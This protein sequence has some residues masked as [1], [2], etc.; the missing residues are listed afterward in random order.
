MP[1]GS[2]S[3]APVINPGPNCPKNLVSGLSGGFPSDVF[4]NVFSDGFIA[5]FHDLGIQQDDQAFLDHRPDFWKNL[6]DL[7]FR[8]HDRDHHRSVVRDAEQTLVVDL[9][10]AAEAH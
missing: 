3:A 10:M 9:P 4:L 1:E 7:M 2:S 6:A 8:V 5:R